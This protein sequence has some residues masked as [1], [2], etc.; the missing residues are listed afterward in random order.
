MIFRSINPNADYY[1][2]YHLIDPDGNEQRM[3]VD[4][5]IL[6]ESQ[7]DESTEFD[8]GNFKIKAYFMDGPIN[9][10]IFKPL[11]G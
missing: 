5:T 6:P 11:L 9:D 1:L 8:R 4:K 7:E 10:G 3:V 2:R